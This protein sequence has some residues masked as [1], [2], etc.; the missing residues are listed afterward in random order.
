M[1]FPATIEVLWR[2]VRFFRLNVR[3]R[4]SGTLVGCWC[5]LLAAFPPEAHPNTF[6]PVS[7]EASDAAPAISCR[8]NVNLFFDS[9][10]CSLLV[11]PDALLE[12]TDGPASDYDIQLFT[13]DNQSAPNP[14]VLDYANQQLQYEITYLPTGES[15]TGALQVRDI[16]P[17]QM[18]CQPAA[19]T[20]L[21]RYKDADGRTQYTPFDPSRPD[22]SEVLEDERGVGEQVGA[23]PLVCSDL[24]S[25]YQVEA[26]WSAPSYP[27]YTGIPTV[28][29]D[30]GGPV[31]LLAVRDRITDTLCTPYALG[32]RIERTFTFADQFGNRRSCSQLITF[33]RPQI[34]LPECRVAL[35]FCTYR[36]EENYLPQELVVTNPESAPFFVN[37]LGQ[38]AYLFEEQCNLTATYEDISTSNPTDCGEQII[39]RWS[40]RDSCWQCLP[41]EMLFTPSDFPCFY[42]G[43]TPEQARTAWEQDYCDFWDGGTFSYEQILQVD[44]Q[45]PPQVSCPAAWDP[46][47]DGKTDDDE[48][49][50]FSPGPFGCAAVIDPPPPRVANEC[51]NWDWEFEIW[52]YAF[53]PQSQ[54]ETFQKIGDSESQVYTGL[55]TGK[56]YLRFVVEDV[57]GNTGANVAEPTEAA[58]GDFCPI[59]VRDRIAPVARCNADLD[60]IFDEGAALEG[61]LL[62]V[63]ATDLD[64][65]S[66]DNCGAVSLRIRREVAG[67]CRDAYTAQTGQ[68]VDS[69][70]GKTE[71]TDRIFF[72]CCDF[73]RSIR[74]ELQVRDAQGNESLCSRTVTP[75]D[76]LAPRCS[77]RD[78]VMS[79]TDIDFD[80]EDTEA[81]AS[82]FGAAADILQVE[83]NC[84]YEIRESAVYEMDDCGEGVIRR[85]FTVVDAGNQESVCEQRIELR[86]VVAYELRFPGNALGVDCSQ[87]QLSDVLASDL[88]C[89]L[90]AISQDTVVVNGIGGACYE[91]EITYRVINWCE[92]SGGD[93]SEPTRIPLDV[94]QDGNTEERTWVEVGRDAALRSCDG[95]LGSFVLKIYGADEDGARAA[96][97]SEIYGLTPGGAPR[98]RYVKV[99][100]TFEYDCLLYDNAAYV[101]SDKNWTPGYFEYTRSVELI[102][103]EPPRFF[104]TQPEPFCMDAA[105]T[106]CSG[107]IDYTFNLREFCRPSTVNLNALVDLNGDGSNDVNLNDSGGLQNLGE[108]QYRVRTELPIG[109]HSLK[110]SAT[111]GCGNFELET[112]RLEIQDCK[113]ATPVCINGLNTELMPFDED[114]DG[115]TDSGRNTIWVSEF[116]ASELQDCSGPLTYSINWKGRPNDPGQ[117]SLTI[118]CD[119]PL[120]ESLP[121]EIHV[122]DGAGNH[123]FCETFIN[124]RDPRDLCTDAPAVRAIA[125]RILTENALPLST[126][127]IKLS[128]RSQQTQTT[129]DDGRFLFN[130]LEAGHD[131]TLTPELDQE[132]VNGVT[133]FDLVLISKHILRIAPLDSPYKIIAADANHSGSITTIDMIQL[134][135]LILSVDRELAFNTSWRFVPATYEFPDPQ[136]PWSQ[137]FPELLNVSDLE[138]NINDADFVAIKVGDINNSVQPPGQ[139]AEARSPSPPVAIEAADGQWRAGSLCSLEI[140]LPA[141]RELQSLQFTLQLA[142]DRAVLEDVQ[143]VMAGAGQ[144][145]LFREES[146]VTLGWHADPQARQAQGVPAVEDRTVLF[147]LFFRVTTSSTTERLLDLNSRYTEAE[148]FDSRGNR[149]E[150]VLRLV[151]A[152]STSGGL[153]VGQNY[154]NPFSQQTTINFFLP[155]SQR[156]ILSVYNGAGKLI[157]R[158]QQHFGTGDHSLELGADVFS[159]HT[160]MLYYTLETD[161]ARASYKMIRKSGY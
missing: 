46:N 141:Y 5:C 30:C 110:L 60:L 82:R 20:H 54:S 58:P 27:Y 92:Y 131:Y 156:V 144:L 155:E 114:G 150:P 135:R 76:R 73:G 42:P 3:V 87:P 119:E 91:E 130:L 160:G 93:V 137:P 12:A 1:K 159:G 140:R 125:G 57:C 124:I 106:N 7:S 96:A 129:G 157:H 108:G 84:T 28:V 102:D 11:T 52:G 113:V 19:V 148:A 39:R 45:A 158:R 14:L 138:E 62:T 90:L 101:R 85:I 109:R 78:T 64:A 41:G 145:G 149:R 31:E 89:N 117:K 34:M 2:L 24:S 147:K 153:S 112:V 44:D 66:T 94:D 95:S 55:D 35:D 21:Y 47:Q 122:R 17:P 22:F 10:T 115:I 74:I 36:D 65:G 13:P 48:A 126:V 53:D 116:I 40:L 81:L 8:G 43:L 61:E 71:W 68:P 23:Y 111:D 107:S 77:V 151:E 143:P 154:P 100:N 26:S 133:T 56:Y 29:D 51:V 132:Y 67:E 59:Y 70:T 86:G 104:Y 15:C 121:V 80:P 63:R 18:D 136:N 128:G 134:R 9:G 79:C 103:N 118:S 72:A 152:A 99:P 6:S 120:Y 37:G 142:P 32:A 83:E 97:P 38:R 127:E 16:E 105:G 75:L 88:G 123:S 50:V 161:D 33:A 139:F 49:P 4:I 146:T 25:I 69:E 98:V